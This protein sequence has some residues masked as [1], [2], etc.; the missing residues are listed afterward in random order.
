MAVS[1]ARGP[2]VCHPLSSH[3]CRHR[4]VRRNTRPE[5]Q[6]LCRCRQEF[7]PSCRDGDRICHLVRCGSRV[8]DLGN[9]CHRRASRGY[10]RPLRVQHVFDARRTFFRSALVSTQPVDG[11]GL[12]SVPLQSYRRGVVH[13]L[14]CRLVSGLGR[15]SIQSTGFGAQCCDG[16]RHQ[17]ISRHRDRCR[18]CSDL[19]DV[20]RHVLCGDPGFCS[21]LCDHG[22]TVIHRVDRRGSGRRRADGRQPCGGSRQTQLVSAGYDVGMDSVRRGVDDHDAGFHSAARCLPTDHVGKK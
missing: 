11:R 21:N 3:F 6:G 15:R 7:A 18:D 2:L 9:L 4:T 22:G 16:G 20:R 5:L 13:A 17:P 19:Y 14:H 8:R 10:R 1:C 12:L